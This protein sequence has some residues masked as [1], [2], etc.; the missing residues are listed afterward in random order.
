MSE[1]LKSPS[2]DTPEVQ[3]SAETVE[4]QGT[5]DTNTED[6]TPVVETEPSVE[7][8][9]KAELEELNKKFEQS[10]KRKNQLEK[11]LEKAANNPE[12]EELKAELQQLKED[13]EREEY[14]KQVASYSKEMNDLFEKSLEGLPEAVKRA[15][16]FNRD[17][18]GVLSIVGDA[19][20]AYQAE[21]NIK[22]FIEELSQTVVIPEP[23]IK[24]DAT[25]PAV[26]PPV[27]EQDLIEA[28]LAKPV[29]E[30]SFAKIARMRINRQQ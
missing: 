15:A 18:F 28:E 14:D 27:T 23:Q 4:G 26:T 2:Q 24:V 19:Q 25:N 5:V 17:K 30:R 21:K 9:S 8:V 3:P 16:R 20:Y 29:S 22:S 7:V 12:V 1:D 6:T 10:E 11:M 13:Q